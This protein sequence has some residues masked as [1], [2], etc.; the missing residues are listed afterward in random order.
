MKKH[1]KRLAVTKKDWEQLGITEKNA[2]FIN[3][4]E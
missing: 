1:L 3:H 2:D 4:Y